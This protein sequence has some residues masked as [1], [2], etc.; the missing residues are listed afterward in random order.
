MLPIMRLAAFA[1]FVLSIFSAVVDVSAR[2]TNAERLA[3]GLGP[4]RPRRLYSG[5]RTNA[6]RAV[7]SGSPGSTQR[8]VIKIVTAGSGG[9]VWAY[10]TAGGA[11]GSTSVTTADTFSYNM[12]SP[13][14][15]LVGFTD[16]TNPS[17]RL[18]AY[19]SSAVHLGSGYATSARLL[20]VLTPATAA[21]S[22][23]VGAESYGYQ[24]GY[25]E[26]TIF[27][28]DPST[29]K[30]T[31]QW[32]NADGSVVY[33]SVYLYQT[34]VYLTGDFLALSGTVATSGWTPVDL[35]YDTVATV[36]AT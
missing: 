15:A 1:V 5:T 30:I 16:V 29:G 19:A 3:R 20:G 7:P 22:P 18:S 27:S 24:G 23:P 11:T 6:A 32:V 8:G 31:V 13:A 28:V 10:M 35:Y 21:G 14:D 33:P 26:T 34:N 12:P 2:A 9:D 25:A 4:A 17:Y 36:S